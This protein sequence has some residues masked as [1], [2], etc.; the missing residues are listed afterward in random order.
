MYTIYKGVISEVFSRLVLRIVLP[1]FLTYKY[2]SKYILEVKT[3][4]NLA[5]FCTK[6]SSKKSSTSIAGNPIL[7]T[8]AGEVLM[9]IGVLPTI[10]TYNMS[11]RLSM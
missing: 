2:R 8:T 4:T 7:T 5:R 11:V 1:F 9:S 10:V 3:F 6:F